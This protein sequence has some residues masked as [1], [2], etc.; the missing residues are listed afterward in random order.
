M[1]RHDRPE[2]AL[3]ILPILIALRQSSY[4]HFKHSR[5]RRTE[6]EQSVSKYAPNAGMDLTQTELS[7]LIHSMMTANTRVVVNRAEI[8]HGFQ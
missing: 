7:H 4:R 8:V 6:I 5:V 2:Y 3:R 1:S